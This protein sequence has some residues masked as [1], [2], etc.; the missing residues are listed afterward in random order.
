MGKK[1]WLE[2]F[3]EPLENKA[4]EIFKNEM[5]FKEDSQA[6]RTLKE[7]ISRYQAN[8]KYQN[9][10]ALLEEANHLRELIL[11]TK[12]PRDVV[13]SLTWLLGIAYDL[14]WP[15]PLYLLQGR[16]KG[17]RAIK[18]KVGIIQAIEKVLL[19]SECRKKDALSLFAY[20]YKNH[21]GP[22][23]ALKVGSYKIFFQIDINGVHEEKMSLLEA[24]KRGMIFEIFKDDDRTLHGIGLSSFRQ[25]VGDV[26]RQLKKDSD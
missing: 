22:E 13:Y 5:S 10:K 3:L 9:A 21:D 24:A 23:N 18:K 2:D 12:T 7:G 17:G 15:K 1:G 8:P 25:Y 11:K 4:K 26:K 20:F 6:R 19:E 14:G 16:S